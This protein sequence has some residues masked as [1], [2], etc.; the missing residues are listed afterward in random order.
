MELLPFMKKRSKVIEIVAAQD[1]VFALAQSGVCAAYSRETNRRICFLNATADEVVRSLFFNKYND[2]LIIVSVYASD[3][4]SSLK[5]R[6][7][8]I[9][10]I[11]RGIADAGFPLF[12]SESLK[13][14]GF[15]EFD[16]VNGKIVTYSAEDRQGLY[17]TN[18]TFYAKICAYLL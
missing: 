11:K 2:S 14:P 16:D 12:E 8:R 3:N 9:E 15:V 13:W 10:C 7:T 18:V 6:S 17:C 5:C 4:F 1:I